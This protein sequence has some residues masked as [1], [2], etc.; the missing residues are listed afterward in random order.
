MRWFSSSLQ[1]DQDGH[2][3][4]LA[5]F[6]GGLCPAPV[7]AHPPWQLSVQTGAGE[8][9]DAGPLCA[10][11]A[12]ACAHTGSSAH[13]AEPDSALGEPLLQLR[14]AGKLEPC[15][16]RCLTIQVNQ[17]PYPLHASF[18]CT[19]QIKLPKL[20]TMQSAAWQSTAQL[21]LACIWLQSGKMST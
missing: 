19:R 13:A 1:D 8:A 6:A 10:P 9:A 14:R 21:R 18:V 12:P 2:E 3:Y 15:A 7:C 17:C 20:Q 11:P 5:G 4:L 16:A